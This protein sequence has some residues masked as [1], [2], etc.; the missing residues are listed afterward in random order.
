MV[1]DVEIKGPSQVRGSSSFSSFSLLGGM[2][3]VDILFSFGGGRGRG[4][5]A[6]AGGAGLGAF[7]GEGGLLILSDAPRVLLFVR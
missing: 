3:V 1:V 7:G 2:G 5:V 4:A 6:L